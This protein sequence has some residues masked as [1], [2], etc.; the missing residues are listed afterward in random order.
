MLA[1]KHAH[2]RGDQCRLD[3]RLNERHIR[4]RA[5]HGAEDCRMTGS[6]DMWEPHFEEA[7]PLIGVRFGAHAKV[8]DASIGLRDYA[9]CQHDIRP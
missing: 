7:A 5:R 9:A 1:C 6:N 2:E 8:S 3:E 4:A